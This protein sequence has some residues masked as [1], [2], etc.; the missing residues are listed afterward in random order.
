VLYP[1]PVYVVATGFGRRR[2]HWRISKG[3]A[4]QSKGSNFPEVNPAQGSSQIVAVIGDGDLSDEV[5]TALEAGGAEVKRLRQPDE[6]DIREALDGSVTSVTVVAREDAFVLRM[7]LFVRSISEDVPL[8]LTIF[9]QTMAEQ[10]SRDIENTQVT[11]LAE[12]VAPSL[13]GPCIDERAVA[14]NVDGER[15]VL[16]VDQD[17]ELS[18]EPI[19]QLKARRLEALARALFTPYD[20]SAGLL[21]YGAIG[22]V[23]IFLIE[24]IT[25]MIVLDNSAV[26]AI[27]GSAKTLVTVDPNLYVDDGPGW[28]K[29]FVS[30][31]MLIALVFAASFTAGLVNRVVERRLTGLVGKRAVPRRDHVVVVGLGQV[32]MRLSL[33]LRGCGVPVVAVEQNPDARSIGLARELGLP[34]VIGRGSDRSLLGRLSLHKARAVAAVTADDLENISVAMT[35]RG[36]EKDIRVVMRVGDGDVANETR[37]LLALGLIR[38]VHRIAAALIASMA[39]GNEAESVVCLGDDAHLRFPDGRLQE[40]ELQTLAE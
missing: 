28:Y 25:A 5:A 30:A 16:L 1:R 4:R 31:T 23:A 36:I 39:L 15:P 40:V 2:E 27:Y 22:L 37:S 33:L 10:V 9:D 17:R 13:A 7:A 35:A 20:K 24:T 8:L 19:P 11:S 14:V 32:G 26:D 34:V 21:L 29:V 3:G 12:I 18:E 38:D 6:E